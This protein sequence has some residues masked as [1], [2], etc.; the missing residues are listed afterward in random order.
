MGIT[1]CH[2]LA[3][4][5]RDV[6]EAR[7]FWGDALG[8]PELERPEAIAHIP[9]VWFQFGGSELHVIQNDAVLPVEGPLAPH[10]AFHTDGFE[11]T[12]E[13]LEAAGVA[14]DFGPGRGP[15]DVLRAVVRD[16]SGNV[17]EITDAPLRDASPPR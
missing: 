10:V 14:F 9:G 16:P 2:H 6:A 15:D 13:R 5:V 12:C 3:V 11:A 7:R 1:G 8:L 17:V 4:C